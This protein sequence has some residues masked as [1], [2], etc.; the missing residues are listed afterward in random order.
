MRDKF[1]R[2]I[3]GTTPWNKELKGI[4]LS[5][6]TEFKKGHPAPETAFK[7]G[8][9]PWSKLHPEL[10]PRG[11][12]SYMWKGGEIKNGHGYILVYSPTH[13]FC[14]AKKYIFRS[15]LVMEK[16]LRRYLVPEEVIHHIN[17]V[18]DDDRPENLKLF[19]NTNEHS[20]FHSKIRFPKGSIF[21][22]NKK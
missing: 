11:A 21:G 6:G 20:R 10:M 1:G 4:H 15:R 8:R 18:K 13:P 12:D 17:G 3:K 22:A 9:T 2:F 19:A 16:H 5:P 14:N 7:K